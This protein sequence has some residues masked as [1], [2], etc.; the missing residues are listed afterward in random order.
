MPPF[1]EAWDCFFLH[2][3]LSAI[4]EYFLTIDD[5]MTGECL[6]LQF[7]SS[8]ERKVDHDQKVTQ[9]YFR[10]KVNVN[11]T[12]NVDITLLVL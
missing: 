4:L 7:L 5:L 10:S 6:D 1:D 8:T 9:I 12:F 2:V 3:S 11:M